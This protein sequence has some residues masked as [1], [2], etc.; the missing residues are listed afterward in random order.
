MI[1][2]VTVYGCDI[3]LFGLYSNEKLYFCGCITH[4]FPHNILNKYAC[5]YE[6][7]TIN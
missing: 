4:C 1:C 7:G 6:T 3:E 5:K 2:D